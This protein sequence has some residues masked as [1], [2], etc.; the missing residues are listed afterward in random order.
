LF[1]L[2]ALLACERAVV[3]ARNF[4]LGELVQTQREPF[5]EST[6]VHEDDRRAV[7]AHELEQRRIDRR[8]DRL[9][10]DLEPGRDPRVRGL[11]LALVE[12]GRRPELAHVL[13]GNDDLE[14]ERF[15]D[16]GVDELDRATAGYEAADLLEGTLR[17]RQR[18]A[19]ER[20][21]A[22]EALEPFDG[23]RKM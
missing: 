16:A 4:L 5:G 13:H 3:R 17:R 23:K 9:A 14:V 6:V 18:D 22:D 2:H 7:L 10:A 8:P 11:V 19:L 12:R 1:D 20:R 15:R 21:L